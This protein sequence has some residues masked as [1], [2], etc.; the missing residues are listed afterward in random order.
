M[1][2]TAIKSGNNNNN[3]RK[4]KCIMNESDNIK[5]VRV[6]QQNIKPTITNT[7]TQTSS[8]QS[9]QSPK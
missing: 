1:I 9:Q 2:T 8:S 6:G 5:R 4:N 7:I 3:E